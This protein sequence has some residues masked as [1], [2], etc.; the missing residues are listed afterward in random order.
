MPLLAYTMIGKVKMNIRTVM[1]AM[2]ALVTTPALAQ[3]EQ[4]SSMNI[5]WSTFAEG[6]YVDVEYG[7]VGGA[8]SGYEDR[9]RAY[10]EDVYDQTFSEPDYSPDSDL[11]PILPPIFPPPIFPPPPP[12]QE[13]SEP[14]VYGG[15]GPEKLNSFKRISVGKSL[16][17]KFG[18]EMGVFQTA[19]VRETTYITH[20]SPPIGED[21]V[22]YECAY[23]EKNSPP[24]DFNCMAENLTK[25]HASGIDLIALYQPFDDFG[26]R[27][28]G[29]AHYSNVKTHQSGQ[30]LEKVDGYIDLVT[31]KWVEGYEHIKATDPQD[32]RSKGWGYVIGAEYEFD[33]GLVVKATSYGDLGGN[34][35]AST[36]V[37]TIGYRQRF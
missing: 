18:L 7:V 23:F 1:V 37:I 2:T 34:S 26:L 9:H 35:N 22:G 24:A 27:L 11:I 19:T 28:R 15:Y 4:G 14:G 6:F 5:N 29:G 20:Y 36:D 17:D 10:S 25:S 31:Y 12:D 30:F 13:V 21:P 33:Y 8:P 3:S 16:T 32:H